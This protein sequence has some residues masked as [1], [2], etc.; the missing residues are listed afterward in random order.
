M[1]TDK[2]HSAATDATTA[3]AKPKASLERVVHL[4]D[5]DPVARDRLDRLMRRAYLPCRGYRDSDEFL[6]RLLDD[7]PGCVLV[8][9]RTPG[10]AGLRTQQRL[11]EAGST[12]SVVFLGDSPEI[13]AAVGAMRAGAE[14]FLAGP[15]DDDTLI[16]T[17]QQ[18]IARDRR[19]KARQVA[20]QALRERLARLTPRERETLEAVV[21]GLSN[22]GIAEALSISPKTV[23]LHRAHMMRKMGA[24]SVA[25]VVKRYL[26][27]TETAAPPIK[28]FP[29]PGHGEYLI[30]N[31]QHRD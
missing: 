29:L 27:A 15:T 14:D 19:R 18:A 20:R 4:I 16:E 23:E 28:G 7:R 22:K 25:E 11:S 21:S 26:F 24:G 3:G 2:G 13:S 1:T 6:L 30:G 8:T 5:E 10:M 31:R 9:L 17:V 12:L